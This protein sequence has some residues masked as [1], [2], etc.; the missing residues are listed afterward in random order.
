M[1][2]ASTSRSDIRRS[3]HER[4]S[5]STR[6]RT[7]VPRK[8]GKAAKLTVPLE[9]PQ[10]SGVCRRYFH[11][12]LTDPHAPMSW[13]MSS[14]AISGINREWEAAPVQGKELADF[15]K[16]LWPKLSPVGVTRRSS[17]YEGV[18]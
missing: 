4:V 2:G 8:R 12:R 11:F 13:A 17:G 15:Y 18:L 14:F 5:S 9:H 16:L 1:P 6:L 10:R 3:G 7:G